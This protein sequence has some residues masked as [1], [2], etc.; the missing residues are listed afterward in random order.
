MIIKNFTS[1]D[2]PAVISLW[3]R[4]LPADTLD[5]E[6]FY[7]RVICDVNFD[8]ELFLLAEE[9]GIPVGFA[10][11][12]KRR[13][14]DEFSGLQ[15]ENAWLV[16]MGVDPKSR[17]Q[18]TGQKLLSALEDT[19][20]GKGALNLDVGTYPC[21]YF[22]P[23]VDTDVYGTGVDFLTKRGYIPKGECCS[24]DINL[25]GYETPMRYLEKKE[26]LIDEGYVFTAFSFGDSLPLF[27]FLRE[28]FPWWLNDVRGAITAGR[29]EKTMVLAKH[30]GKVVGFVMRAFDGC[31]ERFGP[32]GVSPAYQGVGLGGVLFHEM[33]NQLINRRIFYTW[34]LWTSGRNLDIYGAWGMKVYR[35][36][37]MMGKKI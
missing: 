17:K 34:F 20:R 13:V 28:H 21:N 22:C 8:P 31:E 1:Q 12:T 23:G 4:C 33:M 24:M 29:A 2:G 11:G 30:R 7:R 10:Y 32:F 9:N 3:N 6:N 15:P 19:L 5:E 18:G 25:R 14:P 37:T 36:Y 16:A 27:A 35:K 26:K